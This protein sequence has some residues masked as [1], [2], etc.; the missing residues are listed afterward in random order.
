MMIPLGLEK[1]LEKLHAVLAAVS[2]ET[3]SVICLHRSLPSEST[4]SGAVWF[5]N[6]FPVDERCRYALPTFPE[7]IAGVHTHH[8]VAV[9]A[10]AVGVGSSG[11]QVTSL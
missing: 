10:Y 5:V 6:P 1:G 4:L 3:S 8:G 7:S 11:V 9:N 2:S